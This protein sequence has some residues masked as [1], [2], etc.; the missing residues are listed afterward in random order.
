M[1]QSLEKVFSA[2][3]LGTLELK[4]RLIMAPLLT[5]GAEKD[6]SV[7]QRLIDFYAE[8]AKGG[9]G[10]IVVGH[11]IAWESGKL[12][13]GLGLWDDKFIPG[14]RALADA[15]HENGAKISIQLGGKGIGQDSGVEGVAPSPVAASW[16]PVPPRALRVDE[17][18]GYVSSYGS[19][20][21]RVQLAGFDAVTIHAAHGKLVSQ[22]LS[23]YLNRRT[24]EYGGSVENRTRFL[25]EIIEEIHKQCGA[26]FPIIVRMNGSDYLEGGITIEDAI[27]QTKIL[28][29]TGIAALEISG[30]TQ[31]MFRYRGMA[32]MLPEGQHV[33]LAAQV[34]QHI[35]KV[36]IIAVGK[37]GN[38]FL[39]EQVLKE[40]K[41]DFISLGR[42]LIADPYLPQKGQEGR[43]DDIRRCL[44]CLN[45]GTWSSR[46][47]RKERGFACTINPDVLREQDFAAQM[48]SAEMKKKVIVIGGGVAGL[49]AAKTLAW[50]GHTVKLFEKEQELGGQWNVAAAPVA[51]G[52]YR[53]LVKMLEKEARTAGVEIVLGKTVTIDDLK[54]EQAD[55]IVLAVGATP[56][57][58]NS[59]DG[60]AL[61]PQIVTGNDILMKKAETGSQVVVI[62]GR[63]IGMEAAAELAEAGKHVVLVEGKTIG[64]GTNKK[65]FEPLLSRFLQAGGKFFDN[66]PVMRFVKDG[67]DIAKGG[68]MLHLQADTIVLA[69]GTVPDT[70]LKEALEREN[71][72]F[73]EIGDC[74]KIGDALESIS[75]GAEI[76]RM[77]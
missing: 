29:N 57:M 1:E 6:Y 49:E 5:R 21:R 77:L 75:D 8:R 32:Y 65:I 72:K 59:I 54:Q 20:A 22:F 11:S 53:T 52:S 26:D 46:P 66:A 71:M 10:L 31:E 43:F 33:P 19:A 37:L 69:V 25:R 55:E 56:R 4:N 61:A 44:Y 7:S 68:M 50:R 28:E 9:V 38:L 47:H 12:E 48:R 39:A 64:N 17:I 30:G 18:R 2:G 40:G 63:Y 62:G 60:Y 3:K 14:L 74:K 36:P 34:K 24:D 35:T 76:G 73:Y 23:P 15:V 45:C 67:V 42:P 27:E 51:N 41:A 13:H 58:L 70:E 16:D